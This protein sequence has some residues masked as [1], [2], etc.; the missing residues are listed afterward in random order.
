MSK[1]QLFF[2]LLL[3]FFSIRFIEMASPLFLYKEFDKGSKIKRGMYFPFASCYFNCKSNV[4]QFI[5]FELAVSSCS[6]LF[7]LAFI[8]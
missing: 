7:S 2:P 8:W 1:V 6:F 3:K 4:K 5:D